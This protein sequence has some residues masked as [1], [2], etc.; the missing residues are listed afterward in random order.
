MTNIYY[1]SKH[2][3]INFNINKINIRLPHFNKIVRIQQLKTK[4][5]L[6]KIF[7][8]KIKMIFNKILEIKI[9]NLKRKENLLEEQLN[10]FK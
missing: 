7:L 5:F 2:I 6:S 8:S 3:R 9:H 1:N 10:N 4:F